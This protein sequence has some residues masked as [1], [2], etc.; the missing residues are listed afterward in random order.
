[1]FT[2]LVQARALYEFYYKKTKSKKAIDDARAWEF[3]N[4]WIPPISTLYDD[5]MCAGK[6][7]NKRVFHLVYE[8]SK[9]NAI[10]QQVVNFAQELRQI[11]EIFAKDVKPE[12]SDLVESSLKDGL[13]EAQKMAAHFEIPS[14]F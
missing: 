6:P 8:R 2:S 14:P 10:N 9:T 7:A 3:C 12:F 5:Y 4:S 11:T 13:E 1:M